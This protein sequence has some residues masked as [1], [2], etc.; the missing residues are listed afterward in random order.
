M[1][2]NYADFCFSDALASCSSSVIVKIPYYI[3]TPYYYI[4]TRATAK[5]AH[6]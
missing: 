3:M 4:L 5:V 2:K 6:C 1:L